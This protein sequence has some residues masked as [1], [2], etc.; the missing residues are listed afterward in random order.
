MAARGLTL[1]VQTNAVDR[2]HYALMLAASNAALGGATTLFFAVEGVT[3]L[4]AGA[5]PGLAT[6]SGEPANAYFARLETAGVAHPDDL[7]EALAELDARF[8]VCDTALAVAG[9]RLEDLRDDVRLD[10]T[11][12]TDILA[13]SGENRLLYV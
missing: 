1:I 4:T 5:W 9:Y 10:V 11:G 8:A 2:V 6:A 13:S 12:L 7:V 3:A